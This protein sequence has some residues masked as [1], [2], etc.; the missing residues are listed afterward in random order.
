MGTSQCFS[1][2]CAQSTVARMVVNQAV[3]PAVP[4][5][6]GTCQRAWLESMRMTY[7]TNLYEPSEIRRCHHD[8]LTGRTNFTLF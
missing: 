7:R 1:E 4:P 3:F 2:E 5:V 8:Y 6:R